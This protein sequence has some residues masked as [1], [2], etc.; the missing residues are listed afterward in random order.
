M[1]KRYATLQL[2]TTVNHIRLLRF[3]HPKHVSLSLSLSLSISLS[4]KGAVPTMEKLGKENRKYTSVNAACKKVHPS[5]EF[6]RL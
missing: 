1:Q 5:I 4:A 2:H 6:S 3:T